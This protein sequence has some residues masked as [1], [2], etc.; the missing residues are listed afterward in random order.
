MKN[1]HIKPKTTGGKSG[2]TK[3]SPAVK[4]SSVQKQM[5]VQDKMIN[6]KA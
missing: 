2:T 5:K 3:A 6:K 1:K 4:V